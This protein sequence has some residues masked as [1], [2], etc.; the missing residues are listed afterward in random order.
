M[1]AHNNK[2]GL[3]FTYM[4]SSSNRSGSNNLWHSSGAT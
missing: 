1:V 3:G 4:G 2:K